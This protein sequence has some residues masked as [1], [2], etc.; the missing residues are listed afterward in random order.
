[1]KEP[2]NTKALYRQAQALAGLDQHDAAEVAYNALIKLE[3][4][5]LKA[6]AELVAVKQAAMDVR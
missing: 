6:K 3:P 2:K 5:N 4:D 1:M